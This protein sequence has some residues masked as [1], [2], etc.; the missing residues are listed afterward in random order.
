MVKH[1]ERLTTP[2]PCCVL[3]PLYI[4]LL[5]EIPAIHKQHRYKTGFYSWNKIL[6]HHN[7]F[8]VTL[9]W[10]IIDH[11]FFFALFSNNVLW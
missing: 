4:A 2:L 10:L 1:I 7:L 8:L 6:P 3:C 11:K 5:L 9:H